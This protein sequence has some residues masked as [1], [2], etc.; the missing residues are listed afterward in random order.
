MRLQV[1]LRQAFNR[2][3]RA[4]QSFALVRKKLMNSTFFAAGVNDTLELISN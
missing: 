1:F 3:C 2:R 4:T